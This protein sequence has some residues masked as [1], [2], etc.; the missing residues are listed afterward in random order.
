MCMFDVGGKWPCGGPLCKLN[1]PVDWK[2][3][4]TKILKKKH[5][6][7]KHIEWS[8]ILLLLNAIHFNNRVIHSPWRILQTVRLLILMYPPII[9]HMGLL[10]QSLNWHTLARLRQWPTHRKWWMWKI[11]RVWNT[12]LERGTILGGMLWGQST[13]WI[14]MRWANSYCL[15]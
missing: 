2:L 11:V 9:R 1:A 4:W 15:V 7:S 12:L 8:Q 5:K 10:G 6:T 14:E 13:S 3:G